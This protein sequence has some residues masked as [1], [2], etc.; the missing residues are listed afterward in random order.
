VPQQF[1]QFAEADFENSATKIGTKRALCAELEHPLGD[2]DALNI[3]VV[4]I[5]GLQQVEHNSLLLA[6]TNKSTDNLQHG[7]R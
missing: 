4:R 5:F 3:I 6:N 7:H 2:V 1:D